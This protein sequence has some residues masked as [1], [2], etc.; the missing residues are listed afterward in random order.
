MAI[1]PT[2]ETLRRLRADIGDPEAKVYDD[3]TLAALLA[4]PDVATYDKAVEVAIW[5]LL[6][7]AAVFDRYAGGLKAEEREQVRKGLDRSYVLWREHHRPAG[8][9]PAIGQGGFKYATASSGG[10]L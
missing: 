2:L 1:A 4:E 6:S 7:N 5:R 9:T 3:P 10:E 8:S